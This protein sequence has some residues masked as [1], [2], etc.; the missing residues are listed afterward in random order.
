MKIIISP[1]SQKLPTNSTNPK[2]YPYWDKVVELIKQKLPSANIIQIGVQGEQIISG[3][4]TV[5][6]NL[7]YPEL[8]KLASDCNAWLGVD[9]FFQHFCAYYKIPNGIVIFGQSDPSIF[10]YKCYTNLLKSKKHLRQEQFLFWW[11]ETVKFNPE[12]FVTPE[13][14]AETLFK[15]L[16]VD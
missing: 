4:T 10:G 3:V 7:T 1:Y 16:K 9:N 2:N 11:H 12:V 13:T 8:Y 5:S 14:V 6:H 15:M